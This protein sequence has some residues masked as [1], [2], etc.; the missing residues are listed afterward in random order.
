MPTAMVYM[1]SL[2]IWR[3]KFFDIH[4]VDQRSKLSLLKYFVCWLLTQASVMLYEHST[5]EILPKKSFELVAARG[6]MLGHV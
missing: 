2:N 1:L 5:T 3:Q 6:G 4:C